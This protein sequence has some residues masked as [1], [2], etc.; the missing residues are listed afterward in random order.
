MNTKTGKTLPKIGTVCAQ[1]VRC[2]KPRC[3]CARGELHGPYYAL[4]TRQ[5]GRLRKRYVRLVD[6]PALMQKCDAWRTEER[7][8]RRVREDAWKHW[9]RLIKVVQEGERDA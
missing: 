6:A 3:R 2:G 8:M 1:W 5:G 9:R 4:F 7:V